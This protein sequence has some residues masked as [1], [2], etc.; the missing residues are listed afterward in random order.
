MTKPYTLG[1]GFEG[2]FS[3]I[4]FHGEVITDL[5]GLDLPP[6]YSNLWVE[7]LNKAYKLGFDKS[8]WDEGYNTGHEAGVEGTVTNR[9]E[10]A[11]DEWQN[12]HDDGYDEGFQ[13]GEAQGEQNIL[14]QLDNI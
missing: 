7:Q 12:G 6:E 3:A 5:S 10:Y 13:E 9:E 4:H 1:R 14:D 2:D 11:Q 8:D